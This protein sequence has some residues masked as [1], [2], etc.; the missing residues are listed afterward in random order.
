MDTPES[1]IRGIA[2]GL[3]DIHGKATGIPPIPSPITKSPCYFYVVD[4]EHWVETRNGGRWDLVATDADGP[5]FYLEDATGKVLVDA[6]HAEYNLLRT[7]TRET[8]YKPGMRLK[9]FF[10]GTPKSTGAVGTAE[11]QND[12][13]SYAASVVTRKKGHGFTAERTSGFESYRLTE[14]LIV[15][16]HWYDITGTCA[17]NPESRDEHDRNMIMK[18]T[19]EPTFL[20]TFRSEKEIKQELHDIA[21]KYVFGG[22]IA[23]VVCLRLFL[24]IRGAF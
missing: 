20:I 3:V 17:E 22:G 9:N 23:A 7:V 10:T 8:G 1:P 18:G 19:N 6:H 5:R 15:P 13:W 21:K 16:D 14:C 12:L 24:I 4:I 2:M 11:G